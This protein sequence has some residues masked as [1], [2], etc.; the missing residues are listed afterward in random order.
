MDIHVFPILNPPP[1]SLL[2]PSFRV[3]PVHQPLAHCLMH[4]T[5]DWQSIS[6]VIIYMFQCYSLKLSHLHL[7]AE[8]KSLF[9]TSVSLL[10]S[11]IWGHLYHLS[12]FH[13]YALIYV[14]VF[15]FLTYFS[16]YNRLQ[17]YPVH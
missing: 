5:W 1:T 12:K 16:L 9:F 10:L 11:C 8:S 2:I 17:F 14:L 15:F 6:H 3:I 4:R 7:L 13:I